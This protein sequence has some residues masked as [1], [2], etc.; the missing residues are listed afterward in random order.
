MNLNIVYQIYYY[1]MIVVSSYF[2][3]ISLFNILDMRRRTSLPSLKEG[4]LV[5]VLIPARDEENNIERCVAS[6]EDQDYQNYEILIID[7]NSEDRTFEIIQRLA[8]QNKRIK[9]YKGKPLPPEWYG[10]TFAMEQLY[11]YAKGEILLFTD[12]DTIH[13]P[14]SVSWTVTN[15]KATGADLISGYVGQI[16]KSFGEQITVPTM[17]FLTG[18]VIPMFLNKII[19]IGYFSAA[20]GQ[21]IAVLKETFDKIGGFTKVKHKTSEDIYMAR[22]IK[23][24]GYK[25]EFLD[26]TDQVRCRMY[27]GYA[28]GIK[29]IGKN[30][31]DFT[32]KNP[33]ILMLI[34]FLILFFFCLPFPILVYSV[35]SSLM[36]G[37]LN[38]LMVP[39]VIVHV[40]FTL[41]WLFLFIS[42]R[43]TWYNAFFWPVMYVTLLFM[44]LWSFYRT[45][46]GRGFIWKD[47]VVN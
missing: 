17:F 1:G 22:Y 42:R 27:E 10:K 15:L 16:L 39:L 23:D 3:I 43:I 37:S 6:L 20:V 21:Y 32:G 41:T 14:T 34:A 33:A 8:N 19:K 31:Y 24:C 28:A 26:I 35:V 30:I 40:L 5:S 7:D 2:F 12:A 11:S 38:P 45:V 4:P 29:G 13:S 9:A 36:G 47:R 18:F 46:S 44:V 25:T